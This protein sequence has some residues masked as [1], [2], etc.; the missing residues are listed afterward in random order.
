[1]R[2]NILRVAILIGL[3]FGIAAPA[4]AQ[5]PV[6][7]GTSVAG[8]TVGFGDNDL[9]TFGVP[10]SSAG[11]LSPSVYASI[12]ASSNISI[13]PQLGLLIVSS[14]QETSHV[15]NLT[16]QVNYF[17][18]GRDE[19]SP[20]LFAALGIVDVSNTGTTPKTIAGG[21]GYRKFLGDR[22]VLRGDARLEHFSD[23]GGTALVM[24]LSFG[25]VF[26]R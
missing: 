24:T 3:S 7:A 25:G 9:R 6:E 21:V 4:M 12:F 18:D 14:G 8:L 26:G 19:S 17:T 16:G 22:L 20:Y 15:F 23:N 13:E 2:S 5:T 11:L 10:S 1:V